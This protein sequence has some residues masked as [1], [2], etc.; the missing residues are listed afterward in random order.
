MQALR[1]WM[2]TRKERGKVLREIAGRLRGDR[3][4]NA[5]ELRAT[6]RE[7]RDIADFEQSN[8]ACPHCWTQPKK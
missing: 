8:G 6:A 5:R 2:E 4:A 3:E 1:K 7:L